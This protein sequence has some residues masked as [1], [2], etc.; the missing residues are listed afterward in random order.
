MI[1]FSVVC[2]SGCTSDWCSYFGILPLTKV[3]KKS[4]CTAISLV[5]VMKV[6]SNFQGIKWPRVHADFHFIAIKMCK[7]L[8][9]KIVFKGSQL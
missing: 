7:G 2:L 3:L 8:E 5:L 6:G 9:H 1:L 4:Q